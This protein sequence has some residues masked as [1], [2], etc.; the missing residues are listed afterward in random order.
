[1]I[2]SIDDM[3]WNNWKYLLPLSEDANVLV[4][5]GNCYEIAEAVSGF[6]R[7]VTIICVD[8]NHVVLE[9]G[10]LRN[11]NIADDFSACLSF[12]PFHG[13]ILGPDHK[14]ETL[15]QAQE[16]ASRSPLVFVALMVNF[17]NGAFFNRVDFFKNYLSSFLESF[18]YWSV[19]KYTMLPNF[20]DWRIISPLN[21][22]TTTKNSFQLYNNITL[23]QRT[24]KTLF[25][26]AAEMGIMPYLAP[27]Y[28]L[29]ASKEN[30][31]SLP[32]VRQAIRDIWGMTDFEMAVRRCSAGKG[33]KAILQVMESNG[34]IKG[35]IKITGSLS[36][37]KY[38]KNEFDILQKL[39]KIKFQH[40]FVP[41]VKGYITDQ[42]QWL[43][44]IDAEDKTFNAVRLKVSSKIVQCLIDLNLNT[45]KYSKLEGSKFLRHCLSLIQEERD[46][47]IKSLAEKAVNQA[48]SGLKDIS[49]PFGMAH[50][51]FVAWNIREDAKKLFIIDWE[52]AMEEH[53]P[54][55]DF[56]HFVILGQLTNTSKDIFKIIEKAFSRTG[57]TSELFKYYCH[58]INIASDRAYYLFLLY[59]VDWVLFERANEAPSGASSSEYVSLLNK[60]VQEKEYFEQSWRLIY[61]PEKKSYENS[62]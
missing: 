49:I 30:N 26:S 37:K 50:R 16:I 56:F 61:H 54:C 2:N 51:D 33:N 43:L 62:L 19:R 41:K 17:S 52:W 47:A 35:F 60:M 59:L 22:R 1:M 5:G 9:Q 7:S 38:L 45:R 6:T 40:F 31:F 13:I 23:R 34:K 39:N 28:L 58:Q 8:D 57:R 46:P 14:K 15:L 25:S 32:V 44:L 10:A 29:I 55:M 12:G 24:I 36:R 53:I 20:G 42:K 48:L 3:R 27:N 18:N 11:V 4:L 21:R